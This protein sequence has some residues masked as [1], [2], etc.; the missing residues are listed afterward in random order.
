MLGLLELSASVSAWFGEELLDLWTAWEKLC[1]S[2]LAR[3][4]LKF[5]NQK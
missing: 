4:L 2:T 5:G 1:V 3:I